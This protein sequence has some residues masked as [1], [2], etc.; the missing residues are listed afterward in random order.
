MSR[1]RGKKKK[2]KRLQLIRHSK[3]KTYHY[4]SVDP[5]VTLS[6][7]LQREGG[8]RKGPRPRIHHR[9]ISAHESSQ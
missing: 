3:A 4:V 5:R 9:S 2:E 6:L 7:R 1:V 8:E